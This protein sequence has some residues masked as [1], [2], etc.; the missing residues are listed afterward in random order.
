MLA[1][2]SALVLA[3][4]L[5]AAPAPE[6][7]PGPV[8]APPCRTLGPQERVKVDLDDVPLAAVARLVSCA[9]ARDILFAPPTLGDK[10]ATVLGPT[11]IGRRDLEALWQAILLEHG[12][13]AERHGAF[14]VVR[15]AP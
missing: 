4:A 14:E 3:C 2:A 10:R 13:V 7:A 12:L 1:L 5:A 8:P 11:P 6:P 15:P 9:L